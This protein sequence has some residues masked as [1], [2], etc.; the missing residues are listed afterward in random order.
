MGDGACL[1]S[2]LIA[3]V[4]YCLVAGS[5][6]C[7]N[8]ICDRESDRLHPTKCRRPIALGA[9]SVGA[10]YGIMALLLVLAIALTFIYDSTVRH[11][12][13]I[14]VGIYFILNI[15]YCFWL[16]HIALVDVF[17]ISIGFVL[18]VLAGGVVTG[19]WISPWIILMTFLLALFLSFA[20]RRDDVLIYER[21]GD[22][23]R[24]NIARYNLE[25]I[26]MAITLVGVI[27][28]VCYIMYTVS[29]EVIE[30]M[31]TSNLYLTTIW[32][33]AGIL[34]YLQLTV[35]DKNSGSP[36]KILIHDRFIHVCIVGWVLSFGVLAVFD[37]DGTVTTKDTL[38]EFIK[39]VR[40]P[41]SFYAG[42]LRYAP[43][44]LAYKS[45]IYPN[46]KVKQQIFSHFF[47]G[48]RLEDFNRLSE[49]FFQKEGK[50]LVRQ[51]A[52]IAIWEQLQK[53]NRVFIVSASIYNWIKPFASDL[54][55][56]D[57]LS[58]EIE[59]DGEGCL[60]GF[61]SNKNCYGQ[62]RL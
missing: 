59:V 25:F 22:K 14:N 4:I 11:V 20:K 26:N 61:F 7:L 51:S 43:Q 1:S 36:T 41:V 45:G 50:S 17:V 53:C 30:R 24:L 42:F 52:R 49:E 16:K 18:R 44:L 62:E 5:I 12:L 46:W 13:L 3:F 40:G 21:T 34:R 23:M 56:R 35:V 47:K 58:T 31:G 8:D 28:V 9:V 60:T 19:I 57:I 54:G 6:Y 29:P 38:L 48:M 2:A 27:V 10:G 55:I 39:F 15:A 32:V 37:F 33:L